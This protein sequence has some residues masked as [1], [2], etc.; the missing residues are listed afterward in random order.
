M[1]ATNETSRD[2]D[3]VAI[4]A[5]TKDGDSAADHDEPYRFG[6]RP[7]TRAPYPFTERQYARLL[8]MRSRIQAIE[9][10]DDSA[11]DQAAA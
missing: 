7:N 2:L 4:S 8:I 3:E 10:A 11:D 6:R 1:D 5:G 9:S